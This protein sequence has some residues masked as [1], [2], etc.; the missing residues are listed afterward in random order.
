MTSLPAERPR[1]WAPPLDTAPAPA[2]P[3]AQ[4][5]AARY[6]EAASPPEIQWN[7]VIERLLAHRSVRAYRPDAL[8]AGAIETMVASAQSAASSSNL[9]LWSVV[10]VQDPERRARLAELAGG[11]K[12]IVQAPLIL[13]WVADLARAHAIADHADRPVEGLGFLESFL[14]ASID[15]ALAAQNAAVAAES[16]GLGTVYIGALRNKPLEVAKVVGLPPHAFAVFGLVVGWPD[17]AAPPA[18]VKP[19]LPQAAVLHHE[20]YRMEPQVKAAA[21]YDDT[22]KA[23]QRGQGLEPVGW[24]A[25]VLARSRSAASLNG[26]DR[27]REALETLGFPLR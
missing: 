2:S 23:F 12:H 11:Q 17:P 1:A 3:A 5:L 25:S 21:Q 26:R 20:Q 16:L 27:L 7:D 18:Q 8:P 6:G 15:A 19:R 14:V 4:A 22:A 10:A 24:I 13:V 9:Q